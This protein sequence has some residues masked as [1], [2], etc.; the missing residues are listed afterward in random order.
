[1]AADLSE[2]GMAPAKLQPADGLEQLD[3]LLAAQGDALSQALVAPLAEFVASFPSSAVP[4]L[5]SEL[6]DAAGGASGA[7]AEELIAELNALTTVAARESRVQAASSPCSAWARTPPSSRPTS[8][9]S[10]GSTR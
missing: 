5:L 1:M 3:L 4:P 7:G 6:A 9:R 10:W 2:G 8:C